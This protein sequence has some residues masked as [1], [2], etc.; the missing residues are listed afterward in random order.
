M[1]QQIIDLWK[2]SFDDTDDFIR[3]WFDHVYKDDQTLI[4]RQNGQIVSA[5]QILPCEMTYCGTTVPIGYICG[6]CT[7]PAERGKGYMSRLMHQAVA[8]MQNRGYAL[9]VLIPAS[10]QLFDLYRRFEFADAF[11]YS[12]EEIHSEK[13]R[14]CDR[15]EAIQEIKLQRIISYDIHLSDTIYPYYHAKQCERNCSVLHSAR[16]F[17]IICRD[18]M[19]GGC[20]IWL[21][22]ANEQPVGLAFVNQVNDKTLS[23][24][25][26]MY[27]HPTIKNQLIQSIL[28]HH[29]SD[30]A[31]LRIPP[32]PSHSIPYGMAL[33][34]NKV[35]MIDLYCSFYSNARL[36]I[37]FKV[38]NPSLT[39]R[40]LNYNN[41]Q[42]FM[43]LMLD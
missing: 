9:A 39:Q 10:P 27:N 14:H 20:E 31:K 18:Q 19:L 25:E 35:Q 4:I 8:T 1:K 17:D 33:V 29:Q 36:P 24:R 21:A 13:T 2:I 15:S 7:L 6:V 37:Y 30:S 34:I 11:D 5:L 41:R 40:L 23:I 16:Q 3:L 26:I 12:I 28:N 32:T 22:L 38:D 43:N 42:P